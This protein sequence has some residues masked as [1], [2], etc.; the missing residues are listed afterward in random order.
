EFNPGI[1]KPLSDEFTINPEQLDKKYA[2]SMSPYIGT[3]SQLSKRITVYGGLRFSMFYRL[4][5]STI[6]LYENNN[7][8]VF[9][10]DMQIYEKGT[11]IA[12]EYYKKNKVIESYNTFEPRFSISLQLNDDAAI[13]ASYNRMAQYLQ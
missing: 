11:P 12:T 4:G 1:I 7:P 5:A 8:V 3:E 9:N 6:N 13:K 2:L 10:S